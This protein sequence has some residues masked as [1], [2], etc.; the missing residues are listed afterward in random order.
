MPTVFP[1]A[2]AGLISMAVARRLA[3]TGID[4]TLFDD[5]RRG[6]PH[7]VT[8]EMDLELWQL[9]TTIGRD[10]EASRTLRT[11]SPLELAAQLRPG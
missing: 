5:V 9:A 1:Y 2:A 7:N 6:L 3:P 4:P 11:S 8:T 10:P